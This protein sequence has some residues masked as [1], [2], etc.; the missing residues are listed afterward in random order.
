MYEFKKTKNDREYYDNYLKK[1]PILKSYTEKCSDGCYVLITVKNTVNDEDNEQGDSKLIP[2]RISI[3]PGIFPMGYEDS[4]SLIPKV[5]IPINQFI[6]GDV[7]RTDKIL[8]FYQ[9]NL[10][11]DWDNVIID[12]KLINLHSL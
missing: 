12:C 9:I 4:T 7:F 1:I 5:S 10:P 2:Y 6:F 11:Y 3:T 8:T